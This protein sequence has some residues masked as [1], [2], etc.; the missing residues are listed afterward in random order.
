[1]A[2]Q[3]RAAVKFFQVVNSLALHT[4]YELKPTQQFLL[5]APIP[6]SKHSIMHYLIPFNMVLGA[7]NALP[8]SLYGSYLPPV[9]PG[10]ER[11]PPVASDYASGPYKTAVFL[12]FGG[13][14][15]FGTS[16][17]IGRVRTSY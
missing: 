12:S 15:Q 3:F 7:A 4:V 10:S 14:H 5:C 6:F 11:Y 2:S 13:L 8:Q 9:N 16:G 17:A 1:M